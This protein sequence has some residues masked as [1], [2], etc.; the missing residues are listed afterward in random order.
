MPTYLTPAETADL[1]RVKVSTLSTW[2]KR[3]QGPPFVHL[4]RSV[5]YERAAVEAWVQRKTSRAVD[6]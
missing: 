5:R 1:L 6:A 3:E 2:R 4:E